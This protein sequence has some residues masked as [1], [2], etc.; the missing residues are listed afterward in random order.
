VWK[1]SK[2]N[3]E[4]IRNNCIGNFSTI[5]YGDLLNLENKKTGLKLHVNG[6]EESPATQNSKGIVY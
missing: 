4:T 1:I 5:F 6:K 3:Q 2:R